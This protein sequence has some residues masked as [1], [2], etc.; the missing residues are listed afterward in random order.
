MNGLE[1]EKITKK[2]MK[3]IKDYLKETYGEVKPEWNLML[4]ILEENI[5]QYLEV[6]DMIRQTGIYNGTAKNPLLSTSKDLAASIYKIVQ[7]FGISPYA[8]SKIRSM[9]EDDT[10]DFIDT[11]TK[12]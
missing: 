3:G 12:E 7:H 8:A 4:A 5:R 9:G 6:N 1:I 11:L 2:Y 10:E